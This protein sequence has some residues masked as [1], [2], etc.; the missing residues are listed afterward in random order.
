MKLVA[1]SMV[2][3]GGILVKRLSNHQVLKVKG[4]CK[5]NG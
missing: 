3:W 1:M 4:D 5:Q 2:S